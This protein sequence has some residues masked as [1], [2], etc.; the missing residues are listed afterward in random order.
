MT[1]ANLLTKSS[2]TPIV[3]AS[4]EGDDVLNTLGEQQNGLKIKLAA[5]VAKQAQLVAEQAQL[6]QTAHDREVA[7]L[8]DTE[9]SLPDPSAR[10]RAIDAELLPFPGRLHALRDAIDQVG[11]Q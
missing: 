7:G 11:T 3:K 2:K 4:L 1:I 6:R 10:L 5:L 8:L 9:T